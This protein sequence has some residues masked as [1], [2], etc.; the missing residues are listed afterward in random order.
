MRAPGLGWFRLPLFVWSLYSTSV[1][2]LLATPVLAMTLALV[3]VERLWGVGIFDPDLG[4]DPILM[5]H[6]FWFYSHPAVYIMI[7]PGMAVVS[8]VVACFARKPVFGYKF[9]AFPSAI[10][11][12]NWTA[13]LHKGSIR[14]TTPML[15]T[16]GF[17]GLFTIGGLTGL[18]L[19]SMAADLHFQDTY[20]VVA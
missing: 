16:L 17:I 18:H 20:F 6:L 3:A 1:I 10:K 12:F 9:V 14:P 5:Q 11:V 19:A 15:Y 4:G 7:L 8:E 2:S 13:T